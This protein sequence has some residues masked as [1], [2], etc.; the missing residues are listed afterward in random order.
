MRKRTW[1]ISV[2][3]I[4]IAF[5]TM[6][7][8]GFFVTVCSAMDEY[9]H[10]QELRSSMSSSVSPPETPACRMHFWDGIAYRWLAS[11]MKRRNNERPPSRTLL[12]H[13]TLVYVS[14]AL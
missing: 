1:P 5:P 8:I 11:Y 2:Q 12:D 9:Q 4:L 13:V 7:L 10:T 14:N 6:Q 3:P